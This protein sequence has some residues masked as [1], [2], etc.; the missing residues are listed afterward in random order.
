MTAPKFDIYV[1]D[2]RDPGEDEFDTGLSHGYILDVIDEAVSD[3]QGEE[4]TI[5]VRR[6]AS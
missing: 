3:R 6:R 2:G 5:I 1:G 4:L